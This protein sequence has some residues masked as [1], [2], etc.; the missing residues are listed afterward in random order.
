MIKV[1][2]NFTDLYDNYQTRAGLAANVVTMTSNN[3]LYVGTV[4]A[5]NVVSNAQL[6]ANLANYLTSV[7]LTDY[8]TRAD[9][10]ANVAQLGYIHSTG[11]AANVVKLTANST[12]FVGAV[13]AANVVSNAQ[14][15][16]NLSAYQ[17]T[18]GLAANVVLLTSNNS[19]YVNG[20]TESNLNVNSSLTANSST[21]LNTKT[22]GNLNVN[23]ATYAT[24]S[25]TNT[26][27]I[28]TAVYH[29]TNGNMGIANST[30]GQKLVVAGTIESTTGG[31]KFPDGTTQTTAAVSYT[32]PTANSSTLGGVKV[33]SGLSIDGSGVLSVSS[34]PIATKASTL[35]QNGGSGT[36]MTFNWS[37]QSGQPTWLWGG[38]DGTN[39]YVYNPSNFSVNYAT[40]AGSAPASTTLNAVG[41]IALF[42]FD[43]PSSVDG[44]WTMAPGYK[45]LAPGTQFAASELWYTTINFVDQY[46]TTSGSLPGTAYRQYHPSGTWQL[47]GSVDAAVVGVGFYVVALFQ[48][49]S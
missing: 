4:T 32:L 39:H 29:V 38:N 25:S 40:T 21:Y 2:E 47:L 31:L 28:G 48:R 11:L 10:N 23:A 45:T 46:P 8:Q 6:Q 1:N 19:Y 34:A 33:G 7:D 27:T 41:S 42:L 15:Q 26:F 20:K 13:S 22:E 24:S 49:V 9:L 43:S 36:G 3:T 17:T 44:R 37:G 16:A 35:A 5:V 30:P 14:L 18:A 12:N